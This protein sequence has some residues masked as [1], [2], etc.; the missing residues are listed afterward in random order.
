MR[1]SSKLKA[2]LRRAAR[3]LRRP[4]RQQVLVAEAALHLAAAK[5]IL[6]FVPF[7]RWRTQLESESIP[8]QQSLPEIRQVGELVWA[9]N[10]VSSRFPESLNCLPRA[11]AT[12]W[13]M[14]RRQWPNTLQLGVARDVNGKFEAHAWIEHQGKIVIGMVPDL[15]RFVKL[16][17]LGTNR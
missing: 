11:L 10:G 9:I 3:L 12:R 17:P 6:V 7:E 13:M 15:D 14:Q 5:A 1:V 2:E 4:P 8:G 16:P